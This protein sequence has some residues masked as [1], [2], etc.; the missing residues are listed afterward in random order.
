MTG[1]AARV[2][3]DGSVSLLLITLIALVVAVV[4]VGAAA[5]SVYLQH[6]HI[7]SL[8]DS[9]ADGVAAGYDRPAYYATGAGDTLALTDA[10]VRRRAADVVA[11]LPDSVLA[12]VPDTHIVDV[13]L[14]GAS[15]VRVRVTARAHI[16]FVPEFLSEHRVGIPIEA[17]STAEIGVAR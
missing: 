8:A 4:W 5:T 13:G 2:R 14:D 10:S 9:V 12:H 1:Q 11:Q 6:R 16:L 3:E 15:R 7:V 17:S